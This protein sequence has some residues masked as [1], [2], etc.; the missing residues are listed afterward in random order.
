MKRNENAFGDLFKFIT[1]SEIFIIYRFL[2]IKI[3]YI[4]LRHPRGGLLVSN[5]FE[6]NESH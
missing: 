3:G 2:T 5:S 6:I 1:K 4:I